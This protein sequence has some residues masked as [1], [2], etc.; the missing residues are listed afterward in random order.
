MGSTMTTLYR[1]HMVSLQ[2]HHMVFE[3][4][5]LDRQHPVEYAPRR[6]WET[7]RPP[8]QNVTTQPLP[9]AILLYC[10][11]PDCDVPEEKGALQEIAAC[12]PDMLLLAW[13]YPGYGHRRDPTTTHAYTHFGYVKA[14]MEALKQEAVKVLLQVR[15]EYPDLPLVLMGQGFGGNL[16]LHMACERPGEVHA[17]LVHNA[18]TNWSDF[19]WG[20]NVHRHLY[21]RIAFYWW[22]PCLLDTV[23]EVELKLH[24]EKFKGHLL[25]SHDRQEEE[26]AGNWVYMRL[27]QPLREELGK[28]RVHWICPPAH[29]L[30][31][32]K[33]VQWPGVFAHYWK[34]RLEQ[35]LAP[36][37]EQEAPNNR[38]V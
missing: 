18:W 10:H 8:G 1:R 9:R 23:E 12:V 2:Y 31:A 20:T 7:V 3:S 35:W 30:P 28:E 33:T 32:L 38:R 25:F 14:D 11:L 16:A 34:S 24:K 17:V 6:L 19:V 29:A 22:E 4:P 21:R 26:V 13:E 5:P 15:S 37:P 36:V 27:V